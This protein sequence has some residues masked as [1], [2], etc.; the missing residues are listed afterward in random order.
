MAMLVCPIKYCRVFGF[1]PLFAIFVQQAVFLVVDLANYHC[2]TGC[3]DTVVQ[4]FYYLCFFWQ[5]LH[6]SFPKSNTSTK[7]LSYVRVTV[8]RLLPIH[9]RHEYHFT[10][11]IENRI[12]CFVVVPDSQVFNYDFWKF[13][14]RNFFSFR[15]FNLADSP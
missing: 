12:V 8:S 5:N 10:A 1:I 7:F 14:K 4:I 15:R 13:T 2:T 9:H 3:V 11:Y 6:Y